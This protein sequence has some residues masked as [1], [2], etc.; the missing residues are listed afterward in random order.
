LADGTT[1]SRLIQEK[2]M[3]LSDENDPINGNEL[4]LHKKTRHGI[5]LPFLPQNCALMQDVS[6]LC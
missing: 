3:V 1:E 5:M 6:T 2:F 4:H